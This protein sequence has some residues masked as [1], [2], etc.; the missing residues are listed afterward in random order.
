MQNI[1]EIANGIPRH[2][3]Y[4]MNEPV[5]L[6]IEKGEQ[7][8]IVGPNG[9]GK[10]RLVDIITGRWPLLMNEVKYGLQMGK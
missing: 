4:R 3:L 1:I 6:T 10:S 7:I 8:A 9:G 5:N 2:P